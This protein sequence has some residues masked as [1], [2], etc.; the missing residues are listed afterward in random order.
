MR[1]LLQ[2]TFRKLFFIFFLL[3]NIL[4]IYALSLLIKVCLKSRLKRIKFQHLMST[5]IFMQSYLIFCL[6]KHKVFGREEIKCY[7]I[8]IFILI[9]MFSKYQLSIYIIF[10]SETSLW[11]TCSW[12]ITSFSISVVFLVTIFAWFNSSYLYHFLVK[13]TSFFTKWR[14]FRPI[15]WI[16]QIEQ[17]HPWMNKAQVQPYTST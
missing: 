11:K 2:I 14:Y 12:Y 17:N 4:D 16:R 9:L 13:R 8:E 3:F 5:F 10:F 6:R 7:E 1:F 15:R